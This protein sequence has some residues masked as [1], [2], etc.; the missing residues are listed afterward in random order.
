MKV[1][2]TIAGLLLVLIVGLGIATLAGSSSTGDQPG[3]GGRVEQ[4]EMLE[5]DQQMLQR[6]RAWTSPPMTTMIR[7]EPMWTDPDMI[8]AQEEYQAQLDRMLGKRP[9]QP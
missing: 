5:A 1:L 2:T 7:Q 3:T 8:R 9:G 6:M 4:G